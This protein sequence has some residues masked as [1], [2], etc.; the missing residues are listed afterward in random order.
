MITYKSITL[1]FFKAFIS[2]FFLFF[3]SINSPFGGIT[4]DR[5]LSLLI[6]IIVILAFNHKY[7]LFGASILFLL[8]FVSINKLYYVSELAPKYFLFVICMI[9]LYNSFRIGQFNIRFD[10]YFIFSYL[11][12]LII[13]VYSV[14]GFL[15]TGTVPSTFPFLD[16]LSFIRTVNYDHMAQV[17]LS[18]L[19]P[20]LSL[21]YPTPPQLSL[22]L[23]IYSLFFLNKIFYGHS[24]LY[25]FLFISSL[26]LMLL[27]ISRSGI[28]PF[29][30]ISFLYYNYYSNSSIF[31]KYSKILFLFIFVSVSIY[32]FN[33]DLSLL[34]YQRFFDL[35]FESF[36]AGHSTARLVG[37]DLFLNGSIFQMLFGQGIGNYY[38]LHAHMTSLTFLVEI[39]II[40]TIL[41]IFLFAQR[42]IICYK[43]I[44]K[45]PEESE[46]HLFEL[47]LLLLIF[48]AMALYEFTYLVPVY[49]FMGLAVGNSYYESK[50]KTFK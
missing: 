13:S 48:F 8:F 15:T 7:N 22:I 32:I 45:F 36:T 30:F 46:N 21:P 25:L 35:S 34:L 9:T 29:V 44:K 47:M 28:I 50:V 27:T 5:L 39:G 1:F 10:K 6:F 37:I 19:F 26:F 33:Q 38:G 49:V 12:L 2:T 17:N 4:I 42:I 20:R 31:S 43:F 24:K 16:S 14:Y 18:Y 23:A 3:I 40:G 11:V 41:F